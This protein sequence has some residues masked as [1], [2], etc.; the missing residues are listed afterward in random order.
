MANQ[1]RT[2]EVDGKSYALRF[3]YN[4]LAM[5]EEQ[6]GRSVSALQSA[7]GVSQVRAMLWAGL[8]GARLKSGKPR[9]PFTLLQAGDLLDELGIDEATKIVL[10][11]FNASFGPKRE[12]EEGESDSKPDPSRSGMPD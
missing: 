11:A 5:L 12:S 1:E 4:A 6:L 10:G 9:A 3:S 2:F 7:I 8:E